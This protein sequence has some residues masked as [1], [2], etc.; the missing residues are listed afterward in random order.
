MAITYRRDLSRPLTI[1]EMDNNFETAVGGGY[2]ETI[3]EVTA[4]QLKT[5]LVNG[6]DLGLP[7]AVGK[8]LE[9]DKVIFEFNNGTTPYTVVGTEFLV[10]YSSNFNAV[11]TCPDNLL[12]NGADAIAVRHDVDLGYNSGQNTFYTD[13]ED[14]YLSIFDATQGAGTLPTDGDGTLRLKIYHKTITF[15]A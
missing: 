6:I 1:E 7:K 3:V 14:W 15:G 2:T 10:V 4:N 13:N 9:F 11:Y 5:D 8:Y 12:A